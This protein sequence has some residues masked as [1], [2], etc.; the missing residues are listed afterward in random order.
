V[1]ETVNETDLMKL[2]QRFSHVTVASEASPR[3]S[4]V[5]ALRLCLPPQER[6]DYEA[7]DSCGD[8]GLLLKSTSIFFIT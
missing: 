6:Y 8:W 5:T 3:G 1:F 7:F 4:D 2:A